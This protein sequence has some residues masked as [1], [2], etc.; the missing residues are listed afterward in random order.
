M[1]NAK[2]RADLEPPDWK[3]IISVFV[4]K[5]GDRRVIPVM[6]I[7]LQIDISLYDYIF[8]S[9]YAYFFSFQSL[10]TSVTNIHVMQIFFRFRKSQFLFQSFL[11]SVPYPSFNLQKTYFFLW[12][13]NMKSDFLPL[14]M[15]FSDQREINPQAKFVPDFVIESLTTFELIKLGS[16]ETVR[17]FKGYVFPSIKSK[18]SFQ[19]YHIMVHISKFYNLNR[20]GTK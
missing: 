9:L 5:T 13:F 19:F 2:S 1:K 18:D 20:N 15:Y 8:I 14:F 6:Q 3:T 11:P 16:V 17:L 4:P 10:A 12:I 7:F